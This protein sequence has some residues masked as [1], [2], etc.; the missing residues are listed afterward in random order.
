[1]H[2]QV[3]H[4]RHYLLQWVVSHYQQVLYLHR[5]ERSVCFCLSLDFCRLS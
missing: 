1:M 5:Q 4:L 3:H 2:L